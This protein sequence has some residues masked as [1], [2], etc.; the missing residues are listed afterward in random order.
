MIFCGIDISMKTFDVALLINDSYKNK[1][2]SNDLKG[3]KSFHQWF[4]SIKQEVIF[5]MEAT[6]IYCVT[7]A[8]YLHKK[9]FQVVVINPIKTHAFAKLEMLRNKT[10]K[11]DAQM[12][13]R[14]CKYLCDNSQF[15]KNLFKPKSKFFERLQ[16]LATR[17]DQL[18]K[19]QT[20][21]KNR[22]G[23][24]MDKITTRM[25][26][27]ILKLLAK[28]IGQVEDQMRL[29]QKQDEQLD[30]QVKLLISIDGVAEK[31]AWA[32]LAYVGDISLFTNSKQIT[33]HA[34]LNPMQEK[35]GTSLNKS[36]LSKMGQKRLRKAL[37]M[38]AM[39]AVRH[40]PL[41]I[42]HYEKLLKKGKR[43]KVALCAVMRKLLVI[44]YGVLKSGKA[45]DASYKSCQ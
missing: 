2:F 19:M 21:E 15:E 36:S 29:C 9:G 18:K 5:C 31:T 42:A 25:I 45:F 17:L 12:I 28:Q 24:S 14:Y 1:L 13:A 43:K 8:K 7:L 32:I 27:S 30:K 4:K 44:S 23:V 33:S 39:T 34:G 38:P 6:G 10:D 22:L 41:M 26:Q 35:S 11:A 40:N 16:Y 3:I 37:F 20:Q